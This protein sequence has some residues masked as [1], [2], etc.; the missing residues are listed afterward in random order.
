MKKGNDKMQKHTIS[1]DSNLSKSLKEEV[2]SLRGGIVGQA[3]K[4][5]IPSRFEVE[6]HK[7]LPRAIIT[8]AETHKSIEVPLYAYGEV[9]KV[10]NCFFE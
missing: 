6:M 1:T 9:R 2:T 5:K 10:L 8:D 3:N 4:N 7:D